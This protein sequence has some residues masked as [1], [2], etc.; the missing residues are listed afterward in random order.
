MCPNLQ[1]MQ[2]GLPNSPIVLVQSP[3]VTKIFCKFY[4][5]FF[6]VYESAPLV[7]GTWK[8]QGKG[9]VQMAEC[10]QI[11]VQGEVGVAKYCKDDMH[12]QGAIE[13]LCEL[14]TQHRK[15]N[16]FHIQVLIML[17]Q[18]GWTY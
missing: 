11:G 10:Y 16:V 17:Q 8:E 13:A 7:D 9:F 2:N 18:A 6:T 5:K 1:K 14:L 15:T 12:G 4:N 3:K